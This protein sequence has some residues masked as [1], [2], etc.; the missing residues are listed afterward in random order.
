MYDVVVL[1]SS[2]QISSFVIS[3]CVFY[4]A[5]VSQGH[6]S[7]FQKIFLFLR[8]S[9]EYRRPRLSFH[10]DVGWLPAISISISAD[11]LSRCYLH[12]QQWLNDHELDSTSWR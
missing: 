3:V 8:I 6:A 1:S 7:K 11:F 4:E 12:H 9:V 5:S 10:Y 2:L